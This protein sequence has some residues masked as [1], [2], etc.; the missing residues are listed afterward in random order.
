MGDHNDSRSRA[1][2]PRGA[3]EDSTGPQ[4]DSRNRTRSRRNALQDPAVLQQLPSPR[5]TTKA[6]ASSQQAKSRPRLKAFGSTTLTDLG[7]GNHNE[8]NVIDQEDP[9]FESEDSIEVGRGH[10]RDVSIS[11]GDNAALS[12]LDNLAQSPRTPIRIDVKDGSVIQ[13]NSEQVS[14]IQEDNFEDVPGSLEV[15][16]SQAAESLSGKAITSSHIPSELAQTQE[17][18]TTAGKHGLVVA[19]GHPSPPRTLRES[20]GAAASGPALGSDQLASLSRCLKPGATGTEAWLSSRD[21]DTLMELLAGGDLTSIHVRDVESFDSTRMFR[22]AMPDPVILKI[23][24]EHRHHWICI[25]L[26]P[27]LKT[28]FMYDS[29]LDADD[30]SRADVLKHCAVVLSRWQ[31]DW[32]KDGWRLRVDK[33]VSLIFLPRITS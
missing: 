12:F 33:T 30:T 14:T 22:R 21:I 17:T 23:H 8:M 25:V 28:A 7:I 20:D 31:L 19:K 26:S 29:M 16:I 1:G 27:S 4:Q 15:S 6:T 3:F 11:P 5:N 24:Q 13:P 2:S 18:A 9:A 32:Q 10:K